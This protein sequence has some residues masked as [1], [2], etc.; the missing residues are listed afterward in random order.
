LLFKLFMFVIDEDNCELLFRLDKFLL[1][2]VL[3]ADEAPVVV[4]ALFL[5][6]FPLLLRHR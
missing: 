3:A 2:D 1:D 5:L 4:V 6:T